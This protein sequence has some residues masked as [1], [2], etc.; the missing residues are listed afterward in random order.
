MPLGCN[1]KTGSKTDNSALN[2]YSKSVLR[3]QSAYQLTFHLQSLSL[4]FS[5]RQTEIMEMF[6]LHLLPNRRRYFHCK[7]PID[8]AK[9]RTIKESL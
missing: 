3:F 8:R 1:V 6:N 4:W 9:T 7:N 5:L 2:I